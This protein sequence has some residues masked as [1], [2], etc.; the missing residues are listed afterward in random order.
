[1]SNQ[2]MLFKR[3]FDYIIGM[4]LLG[5]LLGIY[6]ACQYS[7]GDLRY[8]FFCIACKYTQY[9]LQSN[10]TC[11]F[12]VILIPYTINYTTFVTYSSLIKKCN[13]FKPRLRHH[14]R[15]KFTCSKIPCLEIPVCLWAKIGIFL[16]KNNFGN[17]TRRSCMWCS[18]RI[19]II[20]HDILSKIE[21]K[22]CNNEL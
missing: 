7:W 14:Y 15:M 18:C 2:I 16:R 8:H 6:L 10:V 9:T 13:V 22:S 1:M 11:S 5:V 17:K 4:K 21:Q 12:R 3:P 20:L 19:S